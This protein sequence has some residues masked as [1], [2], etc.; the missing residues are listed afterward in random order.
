MGITKG[1]RMIIVQ[2]IDDETWERE[3]MLYPYNYVGKEVI[4][5]GYEDEMFLTWP[6]GTKR[7]TDTYYCKMADC[8]NDDDTMW[9]PEYVLARIPM[10]CMFKEVK[11]DIV[12]KTIRERPDRPEI[13]RVR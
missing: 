13:R 5:L 11:H 12:H 2:G 6:D 7:D 3:I 8:T 10:T 4:I 9:L 1:D